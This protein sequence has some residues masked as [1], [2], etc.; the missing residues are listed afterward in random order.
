MEDHYNDIKENSEDA[1]RE[2]ILDDHPCVMA[3]SLVA[4]DNLTI[5]DYKNLLH[6]FP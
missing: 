3:Q 6:L 4:D 1:I 5:R 2:F